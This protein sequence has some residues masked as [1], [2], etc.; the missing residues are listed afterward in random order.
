MVNTG[1]PQVAYRETITRKAEFN[2][3]HKKQTGGAGQFGRVAGYM[4]PDPD[5]E[6][7]FENRITGGSIP[8]A[9]YSRL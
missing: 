2:Y 9:L 1:I 7:V 8:T 4:E 6:F 5:E 3:T